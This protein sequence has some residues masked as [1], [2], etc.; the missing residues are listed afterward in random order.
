MTSGLEKLINCLN[1]AKDENLF[2][3]FNEFYKDKT[4]E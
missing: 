1:D 4:N 2:K 3:N